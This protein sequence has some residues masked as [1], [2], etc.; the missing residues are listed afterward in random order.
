ML[1]LVSLEAPQR[2]GQLP[3]RASET[4]FTWDI[5]VTSNLHVVI[6]WE[7]KREF[8]VMSPKSEM[9]KAYAL[10]WYAMELLLTQAA[11]PGEVWALSIW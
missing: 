1:T 6:P 2:E 11:P 9:S 3:S 7:E 5:S 10:G 8:Q 4:K